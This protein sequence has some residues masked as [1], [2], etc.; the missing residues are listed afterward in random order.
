[1]KNF[2]LALIIVLSATQV[3]A[4]TMFINLKNGKVISLDTNA[5]ESIVYGEEAVSIDSVDIS[6][7]YNYS[8]LPATLTQQGSN[9]T[10]NYDINDHGKVIGKLQ[11]RTIQGFWIEDSSGM[12]C[13]TQKDGRFFWGKA[14]LELQSNG[15]LKGRWGYCDDIPTSD[16]VFIKK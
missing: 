8:G 12:R 15:D 3:F 16:F 2:L 1:M 6:G 10:I 14:V 13:S 5:I 11:G 4:A 7:Q 9:I